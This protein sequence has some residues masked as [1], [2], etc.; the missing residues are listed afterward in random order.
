MGNNVSSDKY[1]TKEKYSTLDY[2]QL[3]YKKRRAISFFTL[4]VLVISIV[5]YFFVLDLIYFSSASVKVSGNLGGIVPSLESITDLGSLDELGIGSGKSARELASYEEILRSRRCLEALV[6]RFDIKNRGDYMYMED[7]IKSFKENNLVIDQE[8]FAGIL[9]IGVYDKD[10]QL[11]KEMVEFLL[12]ELDKINIELNVLNAR[13]NREF[14]EKRY[15]QAK[16]DLIRAEDTLKVYQMIHGI[17]PDL[18]IKAAVQSAVTLESEMKA[19]EIKLDVLKKIL[20]P[21]QVEV[22]T[23]EAKINSLKEKISKIQNSTDFSEFLRLG[24]SPQ[25]LMTYLRLQREVEIQS[26]ILAFLL[27]LYEQAKIEE[28]RDTPTIIVLDRPY[29]AERKS[30]PKRLTMVVLLSVVGFM[31]ACFVVIVRDKLKKIKALM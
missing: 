1:T 23:Q 22:R 19:E 24:N 17:A 26:K 2:I 11:A 15:Y 27:P 13:N 29:V 30:K 16:E 6:V 14:I 10:P 5:L 21:D 4:A 7:A 28:K 12:S 18:Q 31:G 25:I 8:R 20:N 9:N 3:L